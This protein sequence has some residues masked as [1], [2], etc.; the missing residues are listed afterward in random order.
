MCS[1]SPHVFSKYET[2]F[3]CDFTVIFVE[4]FWYDDDVILCNVNVL[5]KFVKVIQYC[6][7]HKY[8]VEGI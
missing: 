1:D 5:L 2:D 6:I 8:Y 4:H 7:L 3:P